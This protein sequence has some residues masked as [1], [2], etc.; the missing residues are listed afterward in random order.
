MAH[1]P[2]RIA[3]VSPANG[4]G[5]DH[6]PAIVS[7][8]VRAWLR[9]RR[10]EPFAACAS[11]Q[12]APGYTEEL[13]A[14]VESEFRASP[15]LSI[16][17]SLGRAI[18][19]AHAHLVEENRLTLPDQRRSAS[20]V[21]VAAR[22]NGVYISRTGTAVVGSIRARGVW[23]RS[24]DPS[25]V[26][27]GVDAPG[28]GRAVTP[29]VTSEFCP[30]EPGDAVLLLPGVSVTEIPDADL[31]A[32]LHDPLDLDRVAALL[33]TARGETCG[34]VIWCPKEE[35]EISP[36]GDW[37][38]WMRATRSPD[39]RTQKSESPIAERPTPPSPPPAIHRSATSVPPPR[40]RFG[41][42]PRD[43]LD[44]LERIRTVAS[45]AP[46]LARWV[47]LPQLAMLL[48]AL[49]VAFFVVRTVAGIAGIGVDHTVADA[50]SIVKEAEANPD[51]TV[52]SALLA[53]AIAIL[54]P[55]AAHDEDARAVLQEARDDLDRIRNIVRVTRVTTY[56]FE[57][58]PAFRPVGLWNTDSGT[59]IL[60]LGGQLL[61]RFDQSAA[62]LKMALR[63][64]DMLA[65]QPLG[66]FVTAA[67]SPAR[68]V[69]SQGQLVL[70]DT[71][72]S[73]VTL[74][75]TGS[76]AQRWWP[77]DNAAWKRPGPSAATYDDFY[78]L[79]TDRAEVW[80]YPARLPG[81]AGTVVAT[82]ADEPQL[83]SA[84]DLATDGNLYVLLPDATIAKLA[85]S[86]GVLPFD[87]TVPDQPLT[88]PVAL[89]AH[90]DLDGVWALEPSASRVVEFTSAGAYV[91][92]YVFPPDMLR[93]AIALNVD[94]DSQ[95]LRI[96]TPQQMVLVQL[97]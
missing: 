5:A 63:P 62:S 38:D 50:R 4:S 85:P 72:R 39:R 97:S 32:A 90:P 43:V 81:A 24:G 68:G 45:A 88:A 6:P 12:G 51:P 55:R 34:L 59:Y 9:E 73:F 41:N 70:M 3:T 95:E 87:A 61:Y 27:A 96:L 82:A 93:N 58:D 78:F 46:M 57:V 20:A 16:T 91:R 17:T 11:I 77:A 64:N 22:P 18:R 66:Q 21:L 37:I 40:L 69:E 23:A 86:G 80:R 10:S 74:D 89:F 30:L 25:P 35:D 28:I 29:N 75:A 54:E 42:R 84:L 26:R 8:A 49:V 83:G 76:T 79:D 67:W 14:D 1:L 47:Q 94:A 33:K 48:A 56:S 71:L 2:L 60:D 15:R 92:Q 19:V 44:A 36:G 53:D 65:G 13:L 7:G 31:A 52:A